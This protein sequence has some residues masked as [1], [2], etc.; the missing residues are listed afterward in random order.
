[1]RWKIF[2]ELQGLIRVDD[3]D[4]RLSTFLS[5]QRR[6]SFER[7][8]HED[9]RAYIGVDLVALIPCCQVVEE[10]SLVQLIDLDHIG[11]TI[12][13]HR[14][15]FESVTKR[16]QHV[17]AFERSDFALFQLFRIDSNLSV[18]AFKVRKRGL[19]G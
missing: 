14:R 3:V 13:C 18:V 4:I 17:A 6:N 16:D 2:L 9:D 11:Y 7:V 19:K 8:K 15:V 12:S 5:A 10:R 1:M